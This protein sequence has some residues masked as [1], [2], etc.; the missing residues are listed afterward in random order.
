MES[1][2]MLNMLNSRERRTRI[3]NHNADRRSRLELQITNKYT[4][5]WPL[6]LLLHLHR[7]TRLAVT[8]ASPLHTQYALMR[9]T[10]YAY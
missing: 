9:C 4:S 8:K 10:S 5:T 2:F 7:V 6:I 1:Y 3:G